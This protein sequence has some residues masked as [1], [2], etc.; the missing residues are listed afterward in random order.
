MVKKNADAERTH[1]TSYVELE[2]MLFTACTQ[3]IGH[4]EDECYGNPELDSPLKEWYEKQQVVREQARITLAQAAL[5]KLSFAEAHAL[6]LG[7]M[8][9]SGNV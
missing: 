2:N 6:G 7:H 9:S 5:K 1:A 8:K 3:L 4:L